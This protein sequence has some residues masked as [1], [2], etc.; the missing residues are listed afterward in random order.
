MIFDREY[1]YLNLYDTLNDWWSCWILEL[2]VIIIFKYIHCLN[3]EWSTAILMEIPLCVKQNF[4]FDVLK[5][6]FCN[7]PWYWFVSCSNFH[8]YIFSLIS[9]F[10]GHI[11]WRIF[12]R[13]T[14]VDSTIIKYAI[15]VLT[16]RN[17]TI[18]N[19]HGSVFHFVLDAVTLTIRTRHSFPNTWISFSSTSNM[20]ELHNLSGFLVYPSLDIFFL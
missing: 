14:R 1:I 6:K 2:L 10:S 3:Q 15:A 9:F 19:Y 18:G 12:N 16:M 13:V 17:V 7:V 20:F 8:C 11:C 4:L 5:S